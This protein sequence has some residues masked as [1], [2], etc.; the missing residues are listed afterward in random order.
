MNATRVARAD[1]LRHGLMDIGRTSSASGVSVKSIRHYEAIG[2][3]QPVSRTRGNYRLYSANDVHTL[4]FIKRARDVGLST[5]DIRNLLALWQ[6]RSLPSTAIKRMAA[7]QI[8]VLKHKLA[9]MEAMMDTLRQL[10]GP[11]V[12]RHRPKSQGRATVPKSPYR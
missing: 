12:A 3:L 4:R 2:L 11:S 5:E 10:A 7:Q 9:D 6:D 8:E 1:A